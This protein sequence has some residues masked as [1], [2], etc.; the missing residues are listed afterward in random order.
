MEQPIQ[1]LLELQGMQD[2]KISQKTLHDIVVQLLFF[3]MARV[4][5]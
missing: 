1:L 3:K 2:K 4:P 5:E